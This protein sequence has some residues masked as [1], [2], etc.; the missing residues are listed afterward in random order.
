[1]AAEATH[2]RFALDLK[3]EL[4]IKNLE[5]YIFGSVYPDSRFIT[6]I[7]RKLTHNS[8]LINKD[9][10][11]N[12]DF[13]KGWITHLIV[14][15]TQSEEIMKSFSELNKQEGDDWWTT[16][17]AIKM[18]QDMGDTKHFDLQN[19]LDFNDL[20]SPNGEDLSKIKEYY[21]IVIDMYKN[22]ED[23]FFKDYENMWVRFNI[24]NKLAEE[25]GRK[26][27]EYLKSSKA[28]GKINKL[29]NN[30]LKNIKRKFL[31]KII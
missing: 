31:P 13:K 15:K 16:I 14:D 1:M 3:K 8:D 19:H 27:N 22:K 23:I 9:F 30:T 26:I 10:I 2:I 7:D 28:R 12:D 20:E 24:G 4:K 29:Y 25:I 21:K 6:R 5:K 11:K 18:I 17:T